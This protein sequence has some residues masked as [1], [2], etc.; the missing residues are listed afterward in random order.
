MSGVAAVTSRVERSGDRDE[1]AAKRR[2][3]KARHVSAGNK[4]F[5][6]ESRR[7]GTMS[8]ALLSCSVSRIQ[9]EVQLQNIHARLPQ[10]S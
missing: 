6:E 5:N 10:Q 9:S 3:M 2:H 1:S 4:K 8:A 7:D